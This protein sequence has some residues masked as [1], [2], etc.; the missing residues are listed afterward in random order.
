MAE[1]DPETAERQARVRAH[2]EGCQR[3][4]WAEEIRTIMAQPKGFATI[5]TVSNKKATEGFPTGSI[6][7]FS[8]DGKGRPIF[9]FSTMSTHTKNL[10]TDPRASLCVTEMDFQGAADARVVLTGNVTVAPEEDQPDLKKQYMESHPNAYW[11]SF[12]D[13]KAYCMDEIL[14]IDFVGGF[15][16]A[17]GV[18]PEEYMEASVDPCLAFAQPVMAHMNDDHEDAT[19]SYIQYLVGAGPVQGAKIKRLDRFGFDVRVKQGEGEGVLRVPFPEPV[20]E[21]PKIKA[22]IVGLSKQVAAM[23]PKDSEPKKEDA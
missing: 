20:T 22:A 3:L 18:T 6:V 23:M 7:A 16:R 4:S 8:T 10:M 2:Q 11:A 1:V 14:N 17:G 9:V 12:G 13:F 15:A 21:R 19:K 5:S